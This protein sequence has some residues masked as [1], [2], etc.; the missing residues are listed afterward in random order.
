MRIFDNVEM[1]EIEAI[2]ANGPGVINPLMIWDEKDVVLFDAGLPGM[3]KKFFEIAADTGVPFERL[4]KVLIT[5]SDMD[6]IGSLAQII[7]IHGGDITVFAHKEEKPYIECELPPLRLKQMEASICS[8]AEPMREQIVIMIEKLKRSYRMFKVIVDKPLEDGEVLQVCGG[9]TCI[10]TP[11]HTPGH[12]SYYIEMFKLLIAGDILQIIDGSL[13]KCPDFT[14][15]DNGANIASLKR[16]RQFEIDKIVC[17]HGGLFHGDASQRIA[18][19][20]SG[21]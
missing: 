19:I 7:N 16:L 4:N 11:G 10:Y 2:L 6:H 8:M 12:M 17:Y 13:E 3:D 14:I 20:A 5:H 15:L 9:I 1:L 18:E 21:L